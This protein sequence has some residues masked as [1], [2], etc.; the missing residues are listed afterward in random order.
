MTG[1]SDSF[2]RPVNYL[3]ISVTDRCNLRCVYCMP[4]NGITLMPHGEILRYEEILRV[5]EAAAAL[6]ISKLRVTGGEPLVR[7]ELAELV[8]KLSSV[9]GIDDIALTTNGVLL[10]QHAAELKAAGLKRVNVSLDTLD[11]G[12]YGR[13]TRYGRLEDVLDGIA[14]AR[15]AGLE[16]VKVNVVV[17]Q[18]MND[19]EALEFARLTVDEGWHVRF[20]ELMPFN[21]DS[22]L[23]FVAASEIRERL[24]AL[25]PLEPCLPGH[26]N[27]PAR[28]FR[29]P[30]AKGTV[31]FISPLSEHFCIKCNRL[32]LTADGKLRPCL[33]SDYEV[34]LKGPLR[35]G[36]SLDELRDL[37]RQAVAAKPDGHHLAEGVQPAGRA[38]RQVGG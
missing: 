37:I 16:P 26:G 19:D 23:S 15:D 2:Q 31:G 11:G 36:A 14:A 24:L 17:M 9:P 3:R 25:G 10:R 13:I 29:F 18:G 32:R 38:M 12:K 30:E 28:Y 7:L 21:S 8:R 34:D 35:N 1:L 6:G 20:I 33:L 5:A 27:G 4:E 22:H